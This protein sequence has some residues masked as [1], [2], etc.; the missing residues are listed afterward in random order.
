MTVVQL[1]PKTAD[2]DVVE[3]LETTLARARRGEVKGVMI[4][5][6]ADTTTYER[7]GTQSVTMVGML[8]IAAQR[9]ARELYD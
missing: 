2:R 1:T 5:T 6:D 8:T 7:A 9:T 4:I 3:M